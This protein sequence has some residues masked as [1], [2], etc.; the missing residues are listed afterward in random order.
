MKAG[1]A[2]HLQ[3]ALVEVLTVVLPAPTD[4][5]SATDAEGEFGGQRGVVGG[6]SFFKADDTQVTAHAVGAVI[7][8]FRCDTDEDCGSA[9]IN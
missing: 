6:S 3:F 9:A 8:L 1:A 7:V 5:E 4:F 2:I